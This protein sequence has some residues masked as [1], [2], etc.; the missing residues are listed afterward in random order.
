MDSGD[1]DDDLRLSPRWRQ[2][3][4]DLFA[5]KYGYG[6]TVPHEE[7]RQALGMP[8]P[9]GKVEVEE[10]E[11]WRIS[12]MGQ[13]ES[14]KAHLLEAQNM[15]LQPV[16]GRGYEVIRPEKQ[17]ELAMRE[18]M[19]R[20]RS[21]LQRMGRRLSFVQRAALTAEQARENADALARLSFLNQQA[22]KARR[23]NFTASVEE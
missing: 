23:L 4:A 22:N 13:I 19:K 7:L 15:D 10:Y 11:R 16:A 20:V 21:E 6:D 3:A 1:E 12:L 17:T 18:G 9:T 5:T 8:T 2:V 14:L